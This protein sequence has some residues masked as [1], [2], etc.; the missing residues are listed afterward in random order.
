MGRY[1]LKILASVCLIMISFF[2]QNCARDLD[3]NQYTNESSSA[4]STQDAAQP[5][6]PATPQPVPEITSVPTNMSVSYLSPLE[7]QV[8]A[9]GADLQYFWYKNNVLLSVEHSAQLRTAQAQEGDSGIYRVEVKNAFGV[10]TAE[11]QVSVV[12]AA[13]QYPPTIPVEGLVKNV[14]VNVVENVN[15]GDIYLTVVGRSVAPLNLVEFKVAAVSGSD[16]R[17]QWYYIN[18]LGFLQ[19]IDGANSAT[20][21]FLVSE[22]D[23]ALEGTYRVEVTNAYGSVMSEAKLIWNHYYNNRGFGS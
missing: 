17:Y 18:A 10:D 20:Y 16:V 2:F 13:N 15:L 4:S 3:I 22:I 7:I 21:S 8:Q 1:S 19:K 12:R 14:T 5:S 23:V 6:A 9:S 11:V